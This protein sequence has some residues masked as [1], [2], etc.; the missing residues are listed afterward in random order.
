MV[1][2]M[3]VYPVMNKYLIEK[4]Y[5]TEIPRLELYDLATKKLY[6]IVDIMK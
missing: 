4:W 1:G 3:K 2:P 5:K 6:Y